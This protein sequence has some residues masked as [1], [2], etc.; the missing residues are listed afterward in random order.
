[1]SRPESVT[2]HLLSLEPPLLQ[3]TTEHSFL[4]RAG[5]GKLNPEVVQ[6]WLVQDTFYTRAYGRF[7]GSLLSS[8]Q[9]P[10]SSTVHVK[11]VSGDGIG[12]DKISI[13]F[14]IFDLLIAALTNIRREM[15]FFEHV[16]ARYAIE[17]PEKPS[18]NT[19]TSNYVGYFEA[20]GARIRGSQSKRDVAAGITM[21]WATE[22]IYLRAWR[23]AKS[24]IAA[25]DLAEDEQTL[26]TTQALHKEFIPN[27]TSPEFEAFVNECARI[28]DDLNGPVSECKEIEEL[29]NIWRTVLNLEVD[30]WPHV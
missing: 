28:A 22:V 4:A 27:W 3:K 19:A 21:L 17:I 29:E 18:Q 9:L 6:A 15:K 20:M 16:A 24:H 8:L 7:I 12:A 5:S 26:L 14:Q 25:S 13:D 2:A 30:F 10:F 1:M 11:R 23:C